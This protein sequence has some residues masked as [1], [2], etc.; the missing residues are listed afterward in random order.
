MPTS[1]LSK[2]YLLGT[3]KQLGCSCILHNSKKTPRAAYIWVLQEDKKKT[4]GQE[5]EK[6]VL[7]PGIQFASTSHQKS[8]NV[9]RINKAKI[10][11]RDVCFP[12]GISN[13]DAKNSK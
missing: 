1:L 13:K 8:R 4:K 2:F 12:G 6:E 10:A 9:N 7:Q 3:Y 5:K 11:C